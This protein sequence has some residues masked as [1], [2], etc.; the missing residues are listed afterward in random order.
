MTKAPQLGLTARATLKNV[1]D[2]D[3]IDVTVHLPARI[4]LLDNWSPE[5]KTPEGKEA[6]AYLV[7]LLG[8]GHSLIVFIPTEHADNLNDL[9]TFGRVLGH[10]WSSPD[11]EESISEIL[12]RMGYATMEKEKK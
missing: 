11:A 3:T 7:Q 2:A 6:K 12:V 10:V 8:Q 1:V 5:L 9:L 4:R